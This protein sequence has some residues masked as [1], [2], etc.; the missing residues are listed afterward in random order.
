MKMSPGILE[1][2]ATPKWE[3][4]R[5]IPVASSSL[6]LVLKKSRRG[7][8]TEPATFQF[9]CIGVTTPPTAGAV[10]VNVAI[11]SFIVIS[12]ESLGGGAYT[13]NAYT[14]GAPA[15][16]SGSLVKSSGTGDATLTFDSWFE[17]PLG[18]LIWQPIESSGR[19]WVRHWFASYT[20]SIITSNCARFLRSTF[21]ELYP[22]A[23]L[24]P[25][26]TGSGEVA[27]RDTGAQ[28]QSPTVTI[29]ADAGSGRAE[30]GAGWTTYSS[31]GQAPVTRY[32][33]SAS[34][35]NTV[36]YTITGVS[37]LAW[38]FF[39]AVNGAKAGIVI[40]ESGVEIS[41]AQYLVG[42]QSGGRYVNQTYLLSLFSDTRFGFAPLAKGL[43]HT[44]TYVVTITWQSGLG[45]RIYD[46]GLLGYYDA[47]NDRDGYPFN[48][49]GYSGLWDN[50]TG[51]SNSAASLYP[52]SRNVYHTAACTRI[53]WNYVKRSNACF[54]GIRIYDSSGTEIDSSK[55]RNL[56]VHANGDRYI[57][58]YRVSSQANTTT[59]AD[60]LPAGQ[61]WVHIWALPDKSVAYTESSQ[62]SYAGSQWSIAD[63]GITTLNSSLGGIPGTDVFLD[64]VKQFVGGGSDPTDG[65]GNLTFAGQVRDSGDAV[66][67]SLSQAGFVSGSHGCET[68][69]SGIVVSVDGVPVSWSAAADGTTWLGKSIQ[70]EFTTQV[71]TQANPTAHWATCAY[72][73]VFTRFGVQVEFTITTTRDIY[74]G[75]FYSGMN[76]AP[77]SAA[78]NGTLLGTGFTKV[79]LEP[80][81]TTA[82]APSGGGTS[83]TSTRPH[84]AACHF[85]PEGH[86]I[87]TEHLNPGEIW[88]EW[89]PG[90]TATLTAERSTTSK[91]YAVVKFD[92]T[93]GG[94]GSLLPSGYT[95]T[96]KQRIRMMFDS[97]IPSV[98]Q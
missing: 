47:T 86:V 73:F 70:I 24:I 69:P 40:T 97:V 44:K 9:H 15:G 11:P 77:N 43:D 74:R 72:K 28:S 71:G 89:T 76:I 14:A 21:S 22:R 62:V 17:Q 46:S 1:P 33:V 2:Q 78:S 92:S 60:E 63:R 48:V 37:R 87:L 88:S 93:A 51:F 59:I 58:L 13:V 6:D 35:S 79:Y 39:Q 81:V 4:L 56:T 83:V 55:Y 52:G 90:A 27:N 98:L 8:S 67:N 54:A 82:V 85:S 50:Y 91:T 30:G 7:E 64:S 53:D 57:D 20:G 38:R 84:R 75:T 31:G 3:R 45:A 12:T 18:A 96:W 36:T 65:T 34:G 94:N 26:G 25:A 42:P 61:Y 66:L 80:N 19:F 49:S 5:N 29:A 16:A 41:A 68:Y 23:D 10:Y 32:V 95:H